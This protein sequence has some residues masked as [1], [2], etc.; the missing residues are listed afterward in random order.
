[1]PVKTRQ[2]QTPLPFKCRKTRNSGKTPQRASVERSQATEVRKLTTVCRTQKDDKNQ[3]QVQGTKTPEKSSSHH[4]GCVRRKSSPC[5]AASQS[6]QML[7]SSP[8]KRTLLQE[9]STNDERRVTP[10]CS[11][12]KMKKENIPVTDVIEDSSVLADDADIFVSPRQNHS[13][14]LKSVNCHVHHVKTSPAKGACVKLECNASPQRSRKDS[15]GE[16]FTSPT[17]RGSLNKTI[18]PLKLEKN[19]GEC[20]K[21]IKQ[22][23]HTALPDR[24]L[25]RDKELGMM[26]LFLRSH[27]TKAQ[28]GSLYISGAPG[29]GKTACL[30]QVLNNEKKLM[31]KA[32]V[33]FVNCMS[34]RHSQGIYGKILEEVLGN[35]RG[36]ISAKEASRRLQKTFTSAGQMI[37]LVLDEIDHLDSKGQEVLYTMFEWPSLPKS[38]LLLIGVANALDLTDRILPRLQARPKCKPELLHFSPYSKDELVAILLDRVQNNCDE[39]VVE[40]VA[41]QLCARKVAA[42]AGDV[43]KALDVCRRAVEMVECDV[44]RQLQFSCRSPGRKTGQTSSATVSSHSGV[45]TVGLKQVSSVISEVYGSSLTTSSNQSQTFPLQQKLTICTVLLMVRG[46]K[47]K[48]ITL[49]KC[50]ET[51][52]KVCKDR[53]V[54]AVEQSEFLSLCQLVESRGVIGL[55][56]SKDP[57]Q[58]KIRLKLNENEVEAA[59][60]DKVL[61]SSI[62]QGDVL[63]KMR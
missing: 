6:G 10:C 46:G 56:F 14:D 4:L 33:I 28:A 36:K 43:R 57:R 2:V 58:S 40:P 41:L 5:D 12:R 59:L 16:K 13:K 35:H 32:Q 20:Y 48:E 17:V 44:K 9:V 52:S 1:M 23:L 47:F 61:L 19:E 37:V 26:T 29:T 27:V 25:C 21:K 62:L 24:L 31:S 55:K 38:R 7:P 54:P 30:S 22:S 53:Q 60:Q 8:R 51:Y 34:V 63:T 45:K 39:N 15:T 42:V 3:T 11:P 50:H 18:T 49:G